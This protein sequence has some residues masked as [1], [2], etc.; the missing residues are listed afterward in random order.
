[1]LIFGPGGSLKLKNAAMQNPIEK[2][3]VQLIVEFTIKLASREW[4]CVPLD[5]SCIRDPGIL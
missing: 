3:P 2:I 5:S 4:T 1:M